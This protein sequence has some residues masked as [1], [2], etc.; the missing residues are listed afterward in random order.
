VCPG[1]AL[2]Q[3]AGSITVVM[4]GRCMGP[5]VTM[6]LALTVCRCQLA[7]HLS[8]CLAACTATQRQNA[9]RCICTVS[10]TDGELQRALH[11]S[12]QQ[13]IQIGM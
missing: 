4:W 5:N 6:I 10:A 2:M 13:H 12:H 7:T 8:S 3:I 1:D 11:T 9:Q